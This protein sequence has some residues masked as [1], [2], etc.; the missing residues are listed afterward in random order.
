[1]SVQGE[2]N[3]STVDIVVA[4]VATET[5]DG[6][7]VA[8]AT[9]ATSS[10]LPALAPAETYQVDSSAYSDSDTESMGEEEYDA[11]VEEGAFQLPTGIDRSNH[12]Y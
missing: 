9:A 2:P 6:Q 10:S 7:V 8:E 12:S 4:S 1:M 11:L 3:A 5:S